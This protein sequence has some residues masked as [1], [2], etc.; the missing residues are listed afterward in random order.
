MIAMRTLV[1]LLFLG[2]IG[3]V[4][5]VLG[6][7]SCEQG[8]VAAGV[9]QFV[10]HDNV[11]TAVAF[12][13]DGAVVASTSIDR[14]VR[15][16]AATDGR[17]L[18]VIVCPAQLFTVAFSPDGQTVAAAG[19]DGAIRQWRASD[20]QLLRTLIGHQATVRSLAFSPSG[21][22]LASIGIGGELRVWDTATGLQSFSVRAHPEIGY[23]VAF[24]N[25]GQTIAT[26]GNE[27]TIRLWSARDAQAIGTLAGHDGPVRAL[28][29][30]HDETLIS[31]GTDATVWIW[32]WVERKPLA[33]LRGHRGLVK[34]VALSSDGRRAVSASGDG[35]VN[36]WA[37]RDRRWLNML[38]GPLEQDGDTGIYGVAIAPGG[39]KI[40]AG[41]TRSIET[42]VL[43]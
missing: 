21:A 11:V 33:T 36:V 29:F 38:G 5:P 41:G 7:G 3:F 18:G 37:P 42:F 2:M 8:K 26:A 14:T 23:A 20:R 24:S 12:S 13:P 9:K 30:G 32:N 6:V 15:L 10:G 28:A 17:A 40:I 27:G 25:D 39:R 35:T 19:V 4:T 22:A 34:S 16:W 1:G 31:G 43:P